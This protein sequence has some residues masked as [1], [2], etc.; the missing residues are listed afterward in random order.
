MFKSLWHDGFYWPGMRGECFDFVRA[1]DECLAFNVGKRGF[2][3]SKTIHAQLPFD[4]WDV[5]LGSFDVVSPRGHKYFLVVVC[6]FTKFT[7]LK[8]LVT[9]EASEIAR[10]LWEIFC[11]FPLPR[12]IVSDRGTE[13]VNAVVNELAGL[14]GVDWRLIASYN[15]RANGSS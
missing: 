4:M 2:H 9:K 8:P 15:P 12:V 6:I 1:C 11:T 7:L 10:V 14:L 13:F 3:P 5:D